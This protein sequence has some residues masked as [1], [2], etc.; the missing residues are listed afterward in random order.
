MSDESWEEQFKQFLRKTGDDFRRAG[1]DIRTE[2]QKLFDAAIDPD[3]Q[4]RVRDRLRELTSWA[5]KAAEDVAGSVESAASTAAR[6]FQCGADGMA[7]N[8]EQP[9]GDQTASSS[10]YRKRAKGKKAS[11]G[12]SKGKSGAKPKR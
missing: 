3:K 11:R 7:A 10:A 4:Q 6:V 12:R 9:R 2:A 8:S 1:E 5:R